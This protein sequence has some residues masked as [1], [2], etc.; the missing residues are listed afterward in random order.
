M[1]TETP[2]D[3]QIQKGIQQS[4][5]NA[6]LFEMYT[7]FVM[8]CASAGNKVKFEQIEQ[9]C[10]GISTEAGELLD[11]LKKCKF[12]E[13]AFDT[14]NAI[15]ECGD[16]LFYMTELLE[17]LDSNIFEVMAANVRKLKV[18]YKGERFD[19]DRSL[20]RDTDKEREVLEE[21]SEKDEAD[22]TCDDCVDAKSRCGYRENNIPCHRYREP[23]SCSTCTKAYPI[24]DPCT[25]SE[26]SKNGEGCTARS[27]LTL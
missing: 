22:K 13:R 21:T 15:E 8:S 24:G 23:G 26:R 10:I 5:I 3:V 18:R 12:Q 19:K 27:P 2:I 16:I 14:T 6:E 1:K 7:K 4:V 17:A 9:G 20:N 25:R 11:N